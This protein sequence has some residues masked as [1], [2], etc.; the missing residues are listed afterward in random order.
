AAGAVIERLALARI[1]DSA[2]LQPIVDRVIA[3]HPDA[4]A[5]LEA[6]KKKSLGFLVGQIMK[7]TRGQA[8]P[9]LVHKMIEERLK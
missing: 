2:A 6:G 9:K 7:S 8:D 5:S 3:D 4:V 1:S